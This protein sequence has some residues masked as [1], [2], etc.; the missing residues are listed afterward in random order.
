M[1]QLSTPSGSGRPA[2][3]EPRALLIQPPVYDFALYDLF[4]QPYGLLRIG[5]WLRDAGYQV[6]LVDALDPPPQ[7]RAPGR[8]RINRERVQ[9][10]AE[11]SGVE[12]AYAR[13]GVPREVLRSRIAQKPADIVF[14]TTGMTYWY[15]GI[16]ETAHMVRQV[17][18]NIPVVAGGIYA[19][20]LPSHC[21]AQVESDLVIAGPADESLPDVLESIGFPAPRGPVPSAPDVLLR[22]ESS[23]LQDAGILRLTEGCPFRCSYCASPVLAARHTAN[24]GSMI[25]QIEELRRVYGISTFA[26]YDDALLAP[27]SRFRHFLEEIVIAHGDREL[28][29]FL[30]NAVH[31]DMIDRSLARL[32]Y[33]AGFREVRFGLE[34]SDPAFHRADRKIDLDHLRDA[35]SSLLGSGFSGRDITAYILMGVPGQEFSTVRETLDFAESLSINVSVSEYSP[36]PGTPAFEK[37]A[38]LSGLD[39][40]EPLYHNSSVYP[41]LSGSVTEGELSEM[42]ATVKRIRGAVV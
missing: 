36:V 25:E 8:G 28:S 16:R 33:R 26:F 30:P 18:P 9:S 13:Y 4:L 5:R 22:S 29:F 23:R 39:L 27:T 7:R 10:P 1:T 12:R 14:V 32:M 2:V 38:E 20:L 24:P 40:A 42:R 34:S 17:L 37:A 3:S 41:L 31:L 19:S 15:P 35:V 21:A 6:R 11:L